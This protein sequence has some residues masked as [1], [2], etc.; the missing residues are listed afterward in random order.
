[1]R[2]T[3]CKYR[4]PNVC[5]NIEEFGLCEG[6]CEL[7]HQTVCKSFWF[8]G[9]CTRQD[10]GFIHPKKVGQRAHTGNGYGNAG[11][12]GHNQN[13][14]DYQQYQGRT[15]YGNRTNR[16]NRNNRRDYQQYQGHTSYWNR[17]NINNGGSYQNYQD[18]P[19]QETHDINTNFL[20]QQPMTGIEQRMEE[21]LWRMKRLEGKQWNKRS[22]RQ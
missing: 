9:F 19:S 12:R 4:H 18:Y 13:G 20:P 3:E 14:R 2:R 16:T 11:N 5:K 21:L 8:K 22:W 7:I 6:K 17:N 15:S 10:C 1:M